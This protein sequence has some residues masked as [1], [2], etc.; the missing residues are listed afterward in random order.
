M[1][2]SSLITVIGLIGILS[3]V[4]FILG[5]ASDVLWPLLAARTLRTKRPATYTTR[6]P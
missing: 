1:S 6:R 3:A 2:Y 4:F 5:L